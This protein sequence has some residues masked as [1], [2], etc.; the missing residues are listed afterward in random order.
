MAD[1]GFS[2]QWVANLLFGIIFVE[3]CMKK[4]E[5]KVGHLSLVPLDPPLII[6][7]INQMVIPQVNKHFTI[8][9]EFAS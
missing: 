2:R 9:F 8:F 3:N 6:G 4:N 5:M 1:P 7:V